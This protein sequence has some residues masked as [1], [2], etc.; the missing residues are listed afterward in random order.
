MLAN[1]TT[2]DSLLSTFVRSLHDTHNVRAVA[3]QGYRLIHAASDYLYLDCGS[4]AWLGKAPNATSCPFKS[5][6]KIYSFDPYKGLEPDRHAQVIGGEALLWSEQSGPENF[7][8]T[9]W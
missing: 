8:P 7:E 9:V 3:D 5:W 1:S 4:G 6:Q 2:L